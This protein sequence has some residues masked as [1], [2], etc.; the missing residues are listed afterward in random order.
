MTTK[1]TPTSLQWHIDRARDSI[2]ARPGWMRDAVGVFYCDGGRVYLRD[3]K[4][5]YDYVT[6]PCCGRAYQ[7][8]DFKCSAHRIFCDVDTAYDQLVRAALAKVEP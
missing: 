2:A 7:L 3:D 1:H 4:S 8:L 6:C 5:R